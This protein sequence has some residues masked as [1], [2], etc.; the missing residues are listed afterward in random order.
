MSTTTIKLQFNDDIRRIPVEKDK[1]TY[2]D[3]LTRI[4]AIYKTITVGELNRIVVKYLDNESDMCTVTSDE[5]LQEAFCSFPTTNQ[6]LKLVISIQA[7]KCEKPAKEW[8]W[9][10]HGKGLCQFRKLCRDGVTLMEE[11]KFE[12]AREI[13]QAQL[14][15]AKTEWQQR[16]PCYLVACCEA[17]LG[18]TDQALEYIEKAVNFG[19]RNLRKLK[20]DPRLESIRSLEKFQQLV[21]IVAERKEARKSDEFRA[22]CRKKITEEWKNK[23]PNWS[24]EGFARKCHWRKFL[25]NNTT[26]AS[27]Q[28]IE[29]S[30]VLEIVKEEKKEETVPLIIEKSEEKPSLVV[31]HQYEKTLTIFEEMGFM[32]RD[33]NI[34]ALNKVNGDAKLAISVILGL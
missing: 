30:P 23:H 22:E 14:K 7:E 4:A 13:F 34:E 19:L 15:E 17:S 8:K 33:Q 24:G 26:S 5:E 27:E 20:E 1:F 28:P 18:N 25:K 10:E 32:N 2:Q 11:S 31:L 9:N 29:K 21:T 12:A 16:I 3:L 6:V